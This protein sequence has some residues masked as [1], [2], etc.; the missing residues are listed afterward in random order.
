MSKRIKITDFTLDDRNFNRHTE[1]GMGLLK[2]SIEKV[3]IIESITVSSDGKV[4]SGNARQEKI[5]EVFPDA[6]PIIVE[7]DGNQPIV[8]KR[9]DI[10][11][12]TKQF[13][14]AALFA[15]TTANKNINLDVNLIQEVLVEEF[16]VNV[17]ELGVEILIEDNFPGELDGIDLTAAELEKIQGDDKTLT[18]RIIIVYPPERRSDLEK[19]IGIKINKVVFDINELT[20][21]K[22]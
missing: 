4:I 14:E 10:L 13:H 9:T 5:S 16:E 3:G 1:E 21:G 2:K 22:R 12:D 6:E 19:L 8:I 20:D 15:N 7:T 18:E 11:S 17:E